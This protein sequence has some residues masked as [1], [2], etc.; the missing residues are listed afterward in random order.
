MSN[1]SFFEEYA[2]QA[3]AKGYCVQCQYPYHDGICDCGNA[4]NEDV[5]AV[6]DRW[7][8]ENGCLDLIDMNFEGLNEMLKN[9]KSKSILFSNREDL[10]SISEFLRKASNLTILASDNPLEGKR[11]F[12]AY[13]VVDGEEMS[14][15]LEYQE[16]KKPDTIYDVTDGNIDAVLGDIDLDKFYRCDLPKERKVL[17]IRRIDSSSSEISYGYRFSLSII[18]HYSDRVGHLIVR[19]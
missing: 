19:D 1:N 2:K 16:Y 12:V 10:E 18:K 11:G 8:K 6:A 5:I 13:N 15:K 17:Y 14:I 3:K 7:Y 9:E 4:N